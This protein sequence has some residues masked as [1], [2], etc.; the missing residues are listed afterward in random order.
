M[1]Y[2]ERTRGF[3]LFFHVVEKFYFHSLKDGREKRV[4]FALLHL[5]HCKNQWKNNPNANKA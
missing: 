5:V 2:I 3:Y 1:I 4:L